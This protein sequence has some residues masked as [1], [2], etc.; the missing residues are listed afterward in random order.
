MRIKPINKFVKVIGGIMGE[1]DGISLCP[2]GIYTN[3]KSKYV[4]NHEK[5]H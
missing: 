1:F 4:L 5:I 2:F 3:D